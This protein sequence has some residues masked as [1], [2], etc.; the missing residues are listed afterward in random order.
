MS[1]PDQWTG[2]ATKIAGMAADGVASVKSGLRE[3]EEAGYLRRIQSRTEDNTKLSNIVYEILDPRSGGKVDGDDFLLAEKPPAGNPPADPFLP[4]ISPPSC[5]PLSLSPSGNGSDKTLHTNTPPYPP[6][7]AVRNGNGYSP[8][9]NR[10]WELYPRKVGKG[11]A[12]LCWKKRGLDERI[13]EIMASLVEWNKCELW[14][15]DGGQFIANP[16]TWL[17]Q[18]RWED[19]PNS[20]ERLNDMRLETAL[21]SATVETPKRETLHIETADGGSRLVFR[22]E[23][24]AEMAIEDEKRRQM[25]LSNA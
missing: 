10:F 3:L 5:S 25:E 12:A 15:R 18:G 19:E 21:A 17:N 8:A 14:H 13:D 1:R 7:G 4:L 16:L 11:A 6:R 9:F 22:D 2:T 23:L 20:V 24:D